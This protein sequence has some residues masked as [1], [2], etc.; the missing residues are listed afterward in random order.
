MARA[1]FA[2]AKGRFAMATGAQKVHKNYR[3][4]ILKRLISRGLVKFLINHR[5]REFVLGEKGR[6]TQPAAA[7]VAFE[8]GREIPERALFCGD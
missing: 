2:Y 7:K 3:L 8:S 6:L 4:E 5:G 1:E